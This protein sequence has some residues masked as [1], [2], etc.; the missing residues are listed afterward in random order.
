MPI[1][2][3]RKEKIVFT[4]EE[5]D[6]LIFDSLDG[7]HCVKDEAARNERLDLYLYNCVNLVSAIMLFERGNNTKV[8]IPIIAEKY[9]RRFWDKKYKD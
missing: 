7:N 5:Y 6:E 9:H 8:N 1:K 2:R 3:A 4:P